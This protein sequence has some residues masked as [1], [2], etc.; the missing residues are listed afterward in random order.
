[1]VAILKPR[2]S[3]PKPPARIKSGD[4]DR[5]VAAC[6]T[7]PKADDALKSRLAAA[8]LIVRNRG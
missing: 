6:D 7:S 5:M 4:F 2:T 8:R 3:A 1:M